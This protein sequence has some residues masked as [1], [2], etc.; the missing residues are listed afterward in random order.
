MAKFHRKSAQI[1]ICSNI[2]LLSSDDELRTCL[3][4]VS[5]YVSD[6]AQVTFDSFRANVARVHYC[7][8][9][10]LT[11]EMV[12]T[13]L[14]ALRSLGLPRMKRTLIDNSTVQLSNGAQTICFYDK[15]EEQSAKQRH[16]S[17]ELE[18]ARGI[19]RL[20]VRFNDNRSCQR[21]A[22]KMG[23]ADRKV[24]NLLSDMVAKQTISHTLEK[25]G[26]DKAINSGSKRFDVLKTYCGAD[27]ANF[28]RLT[29]FLVW[30]DMYGAENLVHLEYAPILITEE[31]SRNCK[32]QEHFTLHLGSGHYYLFQLDRLGN[33][34]E[35]LRPPNVIMYP[36]LPQY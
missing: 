15:Y 9:W 2:H 30:A 22:T 10:R 31:N 33:L 36:E 20:E 11:P 32:Q 24:E 4:G 29:G 7:H 14:W 17:S 25:L 26:L 12:P 8:D 3:E 23:L 16:V 13:Y 34:E 1:L 18:A 35:V 27:R 6:A 21:H 5:Q 19:L 28:L